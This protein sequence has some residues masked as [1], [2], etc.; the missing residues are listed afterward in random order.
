MKKSELIAKIH[1]S[2]P[3]L[4]V[5]QIISL[6]NTVFRT[7]VDSL[8]QGNRVEIRSL[9]SFSLRKRKVQSKFPNSIEAKIIFA[10][11]NTVYFRMGKEFFDHLNPSNER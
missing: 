3:F 11:K 6:I 2:Y 10:E 4:T 1:K 8:S 5:N 9:G 7:L